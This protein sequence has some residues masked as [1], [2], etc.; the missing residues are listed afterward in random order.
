L[1]SGFDFLFNAIGRVG[2]CGAVEK[3]DA[4]VCYTF[5]FRQEI[6]QHGMIAKAPLFM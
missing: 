6:F 2:G 4:R 1:S 3:R 5:W